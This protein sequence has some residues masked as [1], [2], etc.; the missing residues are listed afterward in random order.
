MR[1][2]VYMAKTS[3]LQRLFRSTSV[4]LSL[5]FALLYA[6]VSAVVFVAAYKLADYETTHWI[7]E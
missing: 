7:H 2:I 4:Q 3:V 5:R 1:G 6:L